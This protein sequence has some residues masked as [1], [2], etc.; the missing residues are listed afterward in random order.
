M[1]AEED[2]RRSVRVVR[3]HGARRSGRWKAR[4]ARNIAPKPEIDGGRA[5][6]RGERQAQ[7]S[8]VGRVF[9][10]QI[11]LALLTLTPRRLGG[12]AWSSQFGLWLHADAGGSQR[13]ESLT[14]TGKLW[15]PVSRAGAAPQK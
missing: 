7:T 12:S 3:R 15:K 5:G 9:A 1:S 11:M 14:H 13:Y 8:I 4:R 6:V 2:R 10:V